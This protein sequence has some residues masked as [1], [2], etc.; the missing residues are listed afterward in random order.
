MQLGAS[1]VVE[2]KRFQFAL[3][4]D[5]VKVDV[6]Q[7]GAGSAVFVDEREGR[8]GHVLGASGFEAFRD[9]LHQ[10]RLSRS[11][12]AAQQHDEREET[13]RRQDSGR[14]RSSPRRSE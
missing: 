4:I 10:G 9:P 7:G 2:A 11:E 5:A 12:V 13:V 1:K 6:V 3:G 8:A 14:K